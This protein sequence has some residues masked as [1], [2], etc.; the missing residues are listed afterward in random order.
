VIVTTAAAPTTVQL[1][2]KPPENTH[3]D[4]TTH[5]LNITFTAK[6]FTLVIAH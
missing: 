3:Y 2:G 5:Q 6:T 4:Q 1:D